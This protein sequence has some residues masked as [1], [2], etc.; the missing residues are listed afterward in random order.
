LYGEKVTEEDML[1]KIF[2]TFMHPIYSCSSNTVKGDLRN[3]SN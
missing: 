1:D 2:F 3:I